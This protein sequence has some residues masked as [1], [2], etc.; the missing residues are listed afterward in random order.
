MEKE[1][2]SSCT[3]GVLPIK[4]GGRWLFGDDLIAPP[5]RCKRGPLRLKGGETGAG[6]DC[7][8]LTTNN[9]AHISK[10]ENMGTGDNNLNPFFLMEEHALATARCNRAAA[11]KGQ[12]GTI[13]ANKNKTSAYET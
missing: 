1:Y 6:G 10:V 8:D 2:F 12:R 3:G 5:H 7:V 11:T 13:V 4:S 9:N